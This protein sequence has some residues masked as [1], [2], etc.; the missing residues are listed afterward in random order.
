MLLLAP[1]QMACCVGW[2]QAHRPLTAAWQRWAGCQAAGA[3]AARRR[4]PDGRGGAC[5]AAAGGP[6]RGCRS[7]ACV[8]LLEV[9]GSLLA[10]GAGC[11]PGLRAR[12]AAAAAPGC[13][14]PAAAWAVPAARR[15]PAA[16]PPARCA[17]APLPGAPAAARRRPAPAARLRAWRW[18]ASGGGAGRVEMPGR[19]AQGLA[20]AGAGMPA[21]WLPAPLP[22]GPPGLGT[23]AAPLVCGGVSSAQWAAAAAAVRRGW[24]AR[25]TGGLRLCM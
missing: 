4:P 15:Q 16:A 11:W 5:S 10:A 6:G 23:A 13:R 20:L 14:P 3:A 17:C 12:R 2:L 25:L 8:L 22:C 7:R 19:A 18:T 24:R 9:P 1:Q 21:E